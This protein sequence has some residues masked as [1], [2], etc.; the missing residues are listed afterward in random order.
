MSKFA[1]WH[2]ETLNKL[3]FDLEQECL[4]LR[5]ENAER[6]EDLDSLTE[7]NTALWGLAEERPVALAKCDTHGD[8]SWCVACDELFPEHKPNCDWVRL[9]KG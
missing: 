4:R 2:R 3:A 6:R 7:Q 5:K 1:T 8:R 9:T